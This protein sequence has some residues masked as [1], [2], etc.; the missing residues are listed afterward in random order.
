MTNNEMKS[1]RFA[2]WAIA[3]AKLKLIESLV[4]RDGSCYLAT[5]LRATKI[6]KGVLARGQV[7]ARKSG[8]LVQHGNSWVNYDGAAIREA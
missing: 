4:A 6:T 8:L 1:G 3:R 2:K 7:Q 5:M